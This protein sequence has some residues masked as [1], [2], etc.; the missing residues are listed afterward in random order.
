MYAK[1][2]DPTDV[3][4]EVQDTVYRVYFI[5]ADMTEREMRLTEAKNV[6]EVINWA[7]N[8]SDDEPF[9]VYC[10]HPSDLNPGKMTLERLYYR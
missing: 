7:V 5:E 4:C 3:D 2:V 1:L 9:T 6:V 8:N 10:E